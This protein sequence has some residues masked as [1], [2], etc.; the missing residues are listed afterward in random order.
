MRVAQIIC[1]IFAILFALVAVTACV[2]S[3]ITN[4]GMPPEDGETTL[5]NGLAAVVL[6]ILSI[7]GGFVGGGAGVLGAVLSAVG[8][9]ARSRKARI[10]FRVLLILCLA[11]AVG[12]VLSLI[13]L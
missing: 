11:A 3:V 8:W 5:E 9:N 13:L 4:A 1:L 6:G 12:S 2:F 10:T 7:A